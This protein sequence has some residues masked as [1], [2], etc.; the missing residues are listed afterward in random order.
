[1]NKKRAKEIQLAELIEMTLEQTI[2]FA[3]S[4]LLNS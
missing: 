2:K 3:R 4:L 1:M